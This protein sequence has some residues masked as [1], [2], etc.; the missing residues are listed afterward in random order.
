MIDIIQALQQRNPTL[1][2]Y[3]LVLRAD[4]RARDAG[5]PNRLTPEADAWLAERA[6]GAKFSQETVLLAPYPG[7]M[8]ADRVVAVM[9]FADARQL[10]A[11]ATHWTV[12]PEPPEDEAA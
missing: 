4:A 3:V 7:A 12:D 8:P 6:P 2:P 11:F 5:D 9:A 1:G 10:A